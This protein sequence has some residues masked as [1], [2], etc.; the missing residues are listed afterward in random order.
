MRRSSEAFDEFARTPEA[1]TAEGQREL[2]RLMEQVVEASPRD[3]HYHGVNASRLA[4]LLGRLAGKGEEWA[5]DRGVKAVERFLT[6]V[7]ESDWRYPLYLLARARLYYGRAVQ[8]Y[9]VADIDQAL[10]LIDQ[11]FKSVGP[12]SGIKG[13]AAAAA[14]EL[15]LHR[16]E[17]TGDPTDLEASRS[18]ALQIGWVRNALSIDRYRGAM[19]FGLASTWRFERLGDPEDATS[20]VAMVQYA[21][22]IAQDMQRPDLFDSVAHLG[23]IAYR[24][25]YEVTRDPTHLDT[26]IDNYQSTYDATDEA[27][28]LARAQALDNLGNGLAARFDARGDM[29]DILKAIKCSQTALRL[30]PDD[31]VGLRAVATRNLAAG[32]LTLCEIDGVSEDDVGV[33]EL[34]QEV[35]TRTDDLLREASVP[36]TPFDPARSASRLN[37]TEAVRLL[38]VQ[39]TALLHLAV[40]SAEPLPALERALRVLSQVRAHWEQPYITSA[41]YA[42]GGISQRRLP[43]VYVGAL[44]WRAQLAP[45][46]QPWLRQAFEVGESAKSRL[47]SVQVQ[48]LAVDP[49]GE[50]DPDLAEREQLLLA[51]LARL[52]GQ[53]IRH[54][55]SL[56]PDPLR[57]YRMQRRAELT[58]ELDDVWARLGQ[59]SEAAADYVALRRGTNSRWAAIAAARSDIVVVSLLRAARVEVRASPTRLI[60]LVRTRGRNGTVLLDEFRN[61]PTPD[62]YRRFVAEV[63]ADRGAGARDETWSRLLAPVLRRLGEAVGPI[64]RVVLS[65]PTY[66]RGLPWH[67]AL[68]RAGW[69]STN[70]GSPSVIT[71]PSLTMLVDS[72]TTSGLRWHVPVN[73][74]EASGID[75]PDGIGEGISAPRLIDAS[76]AQGPPVVVGNPTGDLPAAEDEAIAVAQTVGVEPLLGGAG[77]REAVRNALTEASIV[78]L[79]AHAVTDT[80]DPLASRVKLADGDLTVNDLLGGYVRSRIIVLSAC[81][82][83]RG[84]PIAG[85]EVLGLAQVLLRTGV[86]AVVAG[87]WRVPDEATAHLMKAFHSALARGCSV[88][89]ALHEATTRIRA[90]GW[91]QPYYWSGFIVVTGALE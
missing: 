66:G 63:P 43:E 81:E 16:Y 34:I 22:E 21:R 50:I 4:E 28:I 61:D 44:L 15:S 24:A 17:A 74:A 30:L 29:T 72:A 78:H 3:A 88:D 13:T 60:T 42:L 38:A 39:A 64:D 10:P 69:H 18:A 86:G 1:S 26:A 45:D 33:G 84:E 89:S 40:R 37:E 79:A 5:W 85:G 46:P 12:N 31:E 83:A 11:A 59:S 82:G 75:D 68:E 36:E 14:A 32:V 51:Q 87:L 67:L 70:A 54:L 49:P 8:T 80:D 91:Q 41:R 62:A 2:V 19:T 25:L 52:E 9:D 35:L 90:A 53:E 58:R 47:L 57:V 71:L 7:P 76:P 65:P 20:A 55:D 56:A 73:A 6:L 27:E 48:R 23:G 77:T